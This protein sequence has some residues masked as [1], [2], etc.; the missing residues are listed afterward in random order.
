MISFKQF[1]MESTRSFTAYHNTD[2]R[3]VENIVKNGFSVGSK[4][5]RK[6]LYGQGIYF[7]EKPNTR[8]GSEQLKVLLK[9]RNPLIDP[10]GD[11]EY[12][13]NYL[14]AAVQQIGIEIFPDFKMTN[15]KQRAVAIDEYLERNNHD[16]LLTDEYN[17]TIF[18]VKDPRI[19]EIL[20]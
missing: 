1:V 2:K 5:K 20:E 14:G 9:P 6:K 8:W 17:N 7:S 18:V 19:I 10:D 4:T 12:E 13:D 11:I 16:L 3:S 15:S